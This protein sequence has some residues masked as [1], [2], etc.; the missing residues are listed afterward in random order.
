[1]FFV[2]LKLLIRISTAKLF[3]P[4]LYKKYVRNNDIL[5]DDINQ[6]FI[7]RS[8]KS[9]FTLKKKFYHLLFYYPEF[10]F[11]FFWRIKSHLMIW[12][13]L[14]LKNY[15][16]KIFTSSIIQGGLVA[17][18]PF[19][20]V[21]N[22]RKIGKNFTFRNSLTVGNKNNNNELLPTIGNNVEVGANVVIIG[23]IEIGDNVIIGAGS[24]VVKNV[25]SNCVVAGN[26]AKIIKHLNL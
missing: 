12:K 11:V 4:Y 6:N 5:I 26:P 25:P 17:Y 10:A 8:Q 21:I 16:C 18:H 13:I 24:V 7:I 23:D 1:M 20:T 3:L 9:D 14:F 2:R 15:N 19:A 22:A